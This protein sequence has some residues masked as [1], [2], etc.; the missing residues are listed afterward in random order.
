MKMAIL[1]AFLLAGC[2]APNQTVE[3][4]PPE[5]SPSISEIAIDCCLT[6]DGASIYGVVEGESN[7]AF[8]Q[9]N[10]PSPDWG[11]QE[12]T[13]PAVFRTEGGTATTKVLKPPFG[14]FTD[15]V[16]TSGLFLNDTYHFTTF[17]SGQLF[18]CIP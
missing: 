10:G 8:G 14:L 12:S 17:H 1:L 18:C 16:V 4:A 3:D 15:G 6:I 5:T 9:I 2:T 13:R 11:A 7:V